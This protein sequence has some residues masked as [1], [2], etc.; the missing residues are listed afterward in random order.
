MYLTWNVAQMVTVSD[1]FITMQKIRHLEAKGPKNLF[2]LS[3]WT[4]TIWIEDWF[5]LQLGILELFQFW[6]TVTKSVARVT[7]VGL[8]S[9]PRYCLLALTIFKHSSCPGWAI[10][11]G[12]ICWRSV[13]VWVPQVGLQWHNAHMQVSAA[14]AENV[15][16]WENF[17]QLS[18]LGQ[19]KWAFFFHVN[20]APWDLGCFNSD[21]KVSY[22]LYFQEPHANSIFL[23]EN[24]EMLD[25]LQRITWSFID[26]S[27]TNDLA[28]K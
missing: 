25:L 28:S 1:V 20:I 16:Y 8:V 18:K 15:F 11:V 6:V 26:K 17:I 27:S 13:P 7:A 19:N 3:S 2:S 24:V 22:S 23:S 21:L 14:E 12:G 4:T 10:Q 9:Q 5:R